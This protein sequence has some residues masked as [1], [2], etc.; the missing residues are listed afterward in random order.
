M[1]FLEVLILIFFLSLIGIICLFG[2]RAYFSR[3][4]DNKE[5]LK[6]ISSSKPLFSFKINLSFLSG[7][8]LG[9]AKK[10]EF[11]KKHFFNFK[12]YVNGKHPVESSGCRGYWDKLNG[13]NGDK[14]KKE[15]CQDSSVG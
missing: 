3:H 1:T 15:D 9:L 4:L 8:F 11:F 5:L 14:N 6:E 10:S 12:D 13:C 2:C 7:L